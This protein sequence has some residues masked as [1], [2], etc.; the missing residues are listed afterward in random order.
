MSKIFRLET[1]KTIEMDL[2]KKG[3]LEAG[4]IVG[5]TYCKTSDL[6]VDELYTYFAKI[7]GGI[8]PKGP[9]IRDL[10][11]PNRADGT[12]SNGTEVWDYKGF[13]Y[14]GMSCE[15]ETESWS[16]KTPFRGC[17]LLSRKELEFIL[18]M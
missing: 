5:Y 9:T 2:T 7:F 18:S 6:S 12:M 1:R 4:F 15:G 13:R 14:F 11:C 17:H 10:P 8:Y 16:S 3:V